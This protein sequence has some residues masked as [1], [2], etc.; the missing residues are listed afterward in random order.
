MSACSSAP[1][2]QEPEFRS[3]EAQGVTPQQTIASPF[4]RLEISADR[5]SGAYLANSLT[6]F[7]A[8]NPSPPDSWILAPGSFFG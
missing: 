5:C 6:I 4:F 2:S 8:Q 7:R 3:Q 1:R